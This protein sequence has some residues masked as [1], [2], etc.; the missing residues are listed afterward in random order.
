M[1][2]VRVLL[3]LSVSA[4]AQDVCPRYE[5]GSEL[6]N[7][8]NLY[9]V[10]NYLDVHASYESRSDDDHAL[11]LYCYMTAKGA[12]SPTL[13]V[14]PGDI[15]LFTLTNN[16]GSAN[17]SEIPLPFA[18]GSQTMLYPSTTNLHFHGLHAPPGCHVEEV[19]HTVINQGESYTYAL[20]IPQSQSAGMYWYHPHIH[21]IS[22]ATVQ[23]GAS[24]AIIVEGIENVQPAVGGLPEQI[25]IFRDYNSDDTDPTMP[26]FQVTV[27]YAYDPYPDYSAPFLRVQPDQKQFWRALNSASNAILELQLRYEGVAQP[28]DI[29]ALDGVPF[30][31]GKTATLLTKTSIL[32]PP[33][34]RVEFIVTTPGVSVKEAILYTL[35]VD[36]GTEGDINPE[37]PLLNIIP[38]YDAPSP[39]VT[40]PSPSV[41]TPLTRISPRLSQVIARRTRHLYFSSIPVYDND[42]DSDTI[43]FITV[44]GQEPQ[45][46]SMNSLSQPA[47]V[48]VEAGTVEDWI[49]ENR[50]LESHVFHIHQLHFLLVARNQIKVSVDDQ[51][52]LDNVLIPPWDGVSVYPSVTLRMRFDASVTGKFVYHCHILEHE[53]KGMMAVIEVVPR[54]FRF[55]D[56]ESGFFS[57]FAPTSSTHPERD[58]ALVFG[59]L[60]VAVVVI[61]GGVITYIRKRKPHWQNLLAETELV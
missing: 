15:L 54:S 42:T 3:L 24:G 46:F 55:R 11:Q 19:L 5:P 44:D 52:Y 22:E 45:A 8:V 28:I 20:Q 34:S 30:G 6:R 16:A 60:L 57:Y 47:S 51:Q 17:N 7:P 14:K 33:A 26:S 48:I 1:L 31:S 41:A 32:L 56:E 37:R 49:I 39:A 36:T 10:N 21:G 61:A 2:L 12:Q 23:G 13:R 50:A 58:G 25:L 4:F 18:C 38:D 59:F 35:T 40:I 43:F 27:N 29:V 53:D 9:S